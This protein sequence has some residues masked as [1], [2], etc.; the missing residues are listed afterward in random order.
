MAEADILSYRVLFFERIEDEF[1]PSDHYPQLALAVA[2]SHD[3]PTL[4]AWLQ[5]SD[6]D[7]KESLGQFSSPKGG[8]QARLGREREREQLVAAFRREEVAPAT[9]RMEV[10]DLIPAAHAYLE[11]SRSLLALAQL[12]DITDQADP[13]NVPSTS[14]EHP[15]WRRRL[16]VTL[17]E[18]E[19]DRRFHL[20]ADALATGRGLSGP[21]E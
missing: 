6:L 18:L 9:P 21:G 13:V 2:G 5:A 7:L 12:G 16:S 3:L 11:R 20:I 4:R 14:D 17:E 8:A 10:R 1:L 19:S 15:N